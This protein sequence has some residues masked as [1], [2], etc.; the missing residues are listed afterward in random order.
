[1]SATDDFSGTDLD[2]IHMVVQSPLTPVRE[3]HAKFFH[4]RPVAVPVQLP[5]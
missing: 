4:V 1:M 3:I 5:A 2:L